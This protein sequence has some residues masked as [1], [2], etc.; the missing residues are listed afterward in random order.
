[1]SYYFKSVSYCDVPQGNRT[2]FFL[3]SNYHLLD[4]LIQTLSA[5]IVDVLQ[6]LLYFAKL[7]DKETKMP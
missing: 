2:V 7:T 6:K 4:I 1:M 5:K 3:V